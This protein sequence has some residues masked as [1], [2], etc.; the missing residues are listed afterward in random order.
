MYQWSE[1]PNAEFTFIIENRQNAL[2]FMT[3]INIIQVKY[4]LK[5]TIL[6]QLQYVLNKYL[7]C[8]QAPYDICFCSVKSHQC[9]GFKYLIVSSC[10]LGST[11]LDTYYSWLRNLNN[12]SS[13]R[14]VYV[15]CFCSL[16]LHQC[17]GNIHLF[18]SSWLF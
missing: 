10:L 9:P 8:L 6:W 3:R 15:I 13:H 17:S 1:S 7:G 14:L 18:V 12:W 16:K 11:S 5:M 2:I 4:I